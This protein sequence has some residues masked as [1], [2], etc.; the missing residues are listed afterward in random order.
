MCE[1]CPCCEPGTQAPALWHMSL[2][3]P[4]DLLHSLEMLVSHGE[5]LQR[6]ALNPQ[7]LLLSLAQACN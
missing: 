2:Q 7:Q 3:L 6:S 4:P 5:T 1:R